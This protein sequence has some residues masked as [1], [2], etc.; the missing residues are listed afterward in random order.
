MSGDVTSVSRLRFV[1][2]RS[3]L[4][5][6]FVGVLLLSL[7]LTGATF[8]GEIRIYNTQQVQ[9]DLQT[10][11]PGVFTLVKR[12]LIRYAYRSQATLQSLR[13]EL[14]GIARD[15]GVRV[16]IIDY[17]NHIAI[18]TNSSANLVT[19]R[20]SRVP[21]SCSAVLDDMAGPTTPRVLN[22]EPSCT[23]VRQTSRL[24]GGGNSFYRACSASFDA[25][26]QGTASPLLV[27]S[28]IIA[29]SPAGID[30][31]ALNSILPKLAAA[32]LLAVMLTLLVVVLIVRAITRP[33]RSITVASEQM[34]R[35]DYDQRVPEE[36]KD[37]VGQ[38]ARSF[39]RM[40]T[41][42]ST[43]RERQRQFIANISHDLKTPLTSIVGFS[44]IL[45]DSDEVTGDPTQRR[46]VQVINEEARR[47]Q[48][49]TQDLLDL[50]RLEAGQLRLRR[51]PIDLNELVGRALA[52]YG[53][54]PA[55]ADLRFRDERSEGALPVW[56][57]A[58]RLMQVMVNLLDNAVKFC[59]AGG[60]VTVNTARLD[61]RA[62]LTVSNTGAGIAAEDLTRVFK[63]F[64]RTDHSRATRT[65]GTGLGLAIVRE[66]VAAHGGKIEAQSETGNWTRFVIS[67]PLGKDAM[68]F[69][70]APR[71]ESE[72]VPSAD[73]KAGIGRP[74][75]VFDRASSKGDTE[76]A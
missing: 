26:L 15:A 5:A 27:R 32:G 37:E 8:W 52:R 61:R 55:Y 13:S 4:F 72:V 44:Q 9:S 28:I 20:A 45:A 73:V 69:G 67:L 12:S 10:S 31:Q 43:A 22:L 1:S 47:L 56:G 49:L 40:A 21:A 25:A 64:Y 3:R 48:R 19:L 58:D 24:P 6:A 41:E 34:A 38:L 17:C 76:S 35:G 54:L 60:T 33:L 30:Q 53:D 68:P 57:D 23:Q 16:L 63:R 29:K 42:V 59:D 70:P 62:V 71:V 7:V 2:L 14:T 50:S 51:A 74:E 46:A 65:G 66:I 11:A 36:R 75:R 18:D 39:N